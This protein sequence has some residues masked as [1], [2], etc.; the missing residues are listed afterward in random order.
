MDKNDKKSVS[1][2]TKEENLVDIYEQVEEFVKFLET[3]IDTYEEK[4]N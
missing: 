1:T 3:Q 4:E 2:D